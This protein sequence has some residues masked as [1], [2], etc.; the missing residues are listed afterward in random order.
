MLTAVVATERVTELPQIKRKCIELDWHTPKWVPH[1]FIYDVTS[2]P[3]P[4]LIPAQVLIPWAILVF[5][6][7]ATTCE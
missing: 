4:N 7:T 6:L 5:V 1:Q 3:L 2:F